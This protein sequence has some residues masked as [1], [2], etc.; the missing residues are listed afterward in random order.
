MAIAVAV[1][2][3]T[4]GRTGVGLGVSTALVGRGAARGG[5][6]QTDDQGLDLEFTA[7][8][9]LQTHLDFPLHAH[10]VDLRGL[11]TG[12]AGELLPAVL[13]HPGDFPFG[14]EAELA[15]I[16][17]G[18]HTTQVD[19]R[20]SRHHTV[21]A[22][23]GEH[24]DHT[25]I[26]ELL[27]LF[28]HAGI[29]D[30][31]AGRI[32][33]FDARLHG[34]ALLDRVGRQLDDITVVD[35]QHVVGRNAHGLG[36]LAV[37]DE[38]AVLAVH[39]HEELGTGEGQ[40]QLLV[41]LEAVARDVDAL[42]L[43]V[44]HLGAQHHQPVN[45]VHH[46]DGVP[47][48]RA[49]GEDDRVARLDLH[50]GVLTAGDAAQ[51]SQR[52]TLT[53]GHEQ[54]GLAVGEVA[55][56]LDR[57]EQIIRSAH[58]AQLT[59]LGDHVEHR[60]AEEADFAAVLH[61]QL[62]DHR[63]AMDR[64]RKGRH[65]HPAFGLGDV[66]IQG[67]EDRTFGGAEAGDFGVGGIAKEAENALLAVMGEAGHIEVFAV[68]RGVV[69]LEV[70]REDD[71]PH[72]GGD[73]QREA[74]CHRVGVPDELH[75]EV[76]ADLHHIPR[77][78]GLDGGAIGDA[79]LLHLSLEHRHGQPGAI[80]HRDV[81][82]LEVVR[83]ATDVVLVTVGHDHSADALLVLLEVAGVGHHDVHAVHPIAG[84]GEA[85]IHEH[86]VVAVLE[87]AGVLADL[88]QATQ[89]NHPQVGLLGGAVTARGLRSHSERGT[90]LSRMG[91]KR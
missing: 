64:A 10:P 24:R 75:R 37:A 1:T 48:D 51:G 38:H 11:A 39:R 78:H 44:D 86:D 30:A 87:H 36:G 29:D 62:Q 21:G 85:R 79:G 8:A 25:V 91:K 31:V 6:N 41:L 84:E 18:D 3:A 63:D 67:R 53:T 5:L 16:S 52:L 28:E 89:G 82:V 33:E 9:A 83:N 22:D 81:E 76:L 54:Q 34:F 88:V 35:D 60:A 55:N 57:N 56:L 40:H 13:E 27:T 2:A 69:E 19:P 4:G 70:T 90:R 15:G 65:D 80:D 7:Q 59:G 12:V 14:P 71:R 73:G 58:V 72:R 43:A 74:V 42:A 20:R 77:P 46:R 47:G 68:D 66:A 45:G 49:R 50:L 17:R 61:G 26:G 32:Q 23:H